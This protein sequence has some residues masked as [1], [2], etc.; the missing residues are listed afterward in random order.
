MRHMW[1]FTD[2]DPVIAFVRGATLA[3]IVGGALICAALVL[4]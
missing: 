2:A 4:V 3:V 1:P